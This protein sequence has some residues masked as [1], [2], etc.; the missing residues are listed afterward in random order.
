[1]IFDSLKCGRLD[2]RRKG[3]F[4]QHVRALCYIF[5]IV[6]CS[7]VQYKKTLRG[8]VTWQEEQEMAKLT[9]S[10]VIDGSDKLRTSTKGMKL[11]CI[12]H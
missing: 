5:K 6:A 3:H 2:T 8:E 4:E 12:V 1:M 9:Q 7:Y 10:L 11:S